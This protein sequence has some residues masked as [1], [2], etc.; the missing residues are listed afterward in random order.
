[1]NIEKLRYPI[2]KFIRP[3]DYNQTILND[4]IESLES[5]PRKLNNT[6]AGLN[7][8]QLDTPYRQDG[9]TVRQ[10]IHHIADSHF[11]SYIR[12]KLS[13]TEIDPTVKPYDE[14]LWAATPDSKEMPIDASLKIIEGVHARWVYML[15]A[16]SEDDF[17]KRFYH[18]ES[19][20]FFAL[21]ES[22]GIYAWHG[23]HHLAQ[24]A[25]LLA[26]MGWVVNQ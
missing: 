3:T 22:I 6:V 13:I 21:K 24:I 17:N 23:N 11:N 9:W 18:P 19:K 7:D 5:F 20:Q 1:M 15:K 26:R 25:C 16:F 14:N 8:Q 4:W 10:V 12:F 2:G